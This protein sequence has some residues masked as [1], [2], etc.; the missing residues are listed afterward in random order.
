MI[1]LPL[2]NS[3]KCIFVSALDAIEDTIWTALVDWKKY[4]EMK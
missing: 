3:N 1:K 4:E 2:L